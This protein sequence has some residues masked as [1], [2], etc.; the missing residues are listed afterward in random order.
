MANVNLLASVLL[1]VLASGFFRS[2]F[3][4]RQSALTLNLCDP[5]QNGKQITI[6][7]VAQNDEGRKVTINGDGS[8]SHYP[9]KIPG[10][11]LLQGREYQFQSEQKTIKSATVSSTANQI[12]VN[13]L[14][15][16]TIIVVDQP[17]DFMNTCPSSAPE[18]LER[19]CKELGV[20]IDVSRLFVCPEQLKK[21]LLKKE[22]V[23]IKPGSQTT[24]ENEPPTY[25]ITDDMLQAS[26]TIAAGVVEGAG[27]VAAARQKYREAR[28]ANP[29]K[30]LGTFAKAFETAA[31]FISFIA[32]VFSVF[33]G[34]ASIATTFLT[35]NPF[36]EM[37]KYLDD[38]FKQINN[39]LTDIQADID[40]LG[41]LIEAKGG[42]L[43]M[44]NQ[45]SAIRYAIR[46]YGVLV[47]AISAKPVCG[48]RELSQTPEVEQF[49]RQY[50]YGESLLTENIDL[51]LVTA[52][53]A[54]L[55]TYKFYK[56]RISFKME[57][58]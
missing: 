22:L 26:A 2:A 43:A 6:D 9:K 29:L 5:L 10:A 18:D 32:P 55:A 49:M 58:T 34:I 40:D 8:Q 48:A 53:R 27:T 39:R 3:S 31:S 51:R 36:D 14:V 11:S 57:E 24:A 37:A 30:K 13:A 35:P 28:R 38:E 46:N 7:I 17:T 47:D 1:L 21:L 44:A 41:R 42:V 4:T 52:F 33:S 15:V 20:S 50:Q 54:I 16:D 45:L 19:P 56:F 25:D 23:Q 12:C